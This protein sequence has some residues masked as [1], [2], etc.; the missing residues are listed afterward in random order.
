MV[1]MHYQ[2][3]F[4]FQKNEF[5]IIFLHKAMKKWPVPGIQVLPYFVLD[6]SNLQSQTIKPTVQKIVSLNSLGQFNGET[7]SLIT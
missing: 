2:T 6:F 1:V 5:L 3:D 7:R 4:K